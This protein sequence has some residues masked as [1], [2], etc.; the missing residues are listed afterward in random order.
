MHS[1]GKRTGI[2]RTLGRILRL[3]W[4]KWRLQ[5]KLDRAGEAFIRG[6]SAPRSWD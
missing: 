3:S 1:F 5:K 4:S 2:I 6:L